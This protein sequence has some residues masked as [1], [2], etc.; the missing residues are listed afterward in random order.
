M[1]A[2]KLRGPEIVVYITKAGKYRARIKPKNEP[3]YEV[4]IGGMNWMEGLTNEHTEVI[5]HKINVIHT[6]ASEERKRLIKRY[7]PNGQ[8]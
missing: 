5:F 8:F 4:T 3:N 2:N 6:R 7:N 1:T